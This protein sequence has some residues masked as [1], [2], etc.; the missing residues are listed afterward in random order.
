MRRRVAHSRDTLQAALLPPTEYMELNYRPALPSAPATVLASVVLGG[1]LLVAVNGLFW[2]LQLVGPFVG[3]LFN[4]TALLCVAFVVL[5]HLNSERVRPRLTWQVIRRRSVLYAAVLL[6]VSVAAFTS[7]SDA[8]FFVFAPALAMTLG[9]SYLAAKQCAYWMTVKPNVRDAAI[10]MGRML[11]RPQVVYFNLRSP[12]E[13]IGSPAVAKLA[14]YSLFAAAAHRTREQRQRVF[15]VVDEFQQVVSESVRLVFEQARS[16][17]V[18]FIV[19]HQNVEQLDR[20]GIDIRDT[21][22]SCTAFKQ[23]FRRANKIADEDSQELAGS[24][25][26]LASVVEKLNDEVETLRQAVD[27]LRAELIDELRKLRDALPVPASNPPYRLT[28]MP[29]DP[30]AEDFG[31]RVNAF[32]A[33]VFDRRPAA[34]SP[35]AQPT[36]ESQSPANQQTLW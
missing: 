14:M 3:Y 8:K 20:K 15:V 12:I 34:D 22:S 30:C 18:H 13:P 6:I 25:Q 28:S 4:L 35:P 9:F 10:D 1:L 17:D 11:S 31:E 5:A 19:A 23:Y 29:Q 33:S 16:S 24:V 27:D 26:D 2:F 36:C 32:D 7:P 21:V